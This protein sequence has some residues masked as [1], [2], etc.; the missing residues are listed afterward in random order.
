MLALVVSHNFTSNVTPLLINTAQL[1]AYRFQLQAT[2][3]G[4][5]SPLD[6]TN[7]IE[8]VARATGTSYSRTLTFG[9]SYMIGAP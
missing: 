5:N 3:G 6:F 2:Y 7:P 8:G 1:V 9:A 4:V